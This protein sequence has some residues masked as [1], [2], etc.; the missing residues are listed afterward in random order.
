[1]IRLTRR[2]GFSASHRLHTPA[3]T[4]QQNA[5]LYGKCNSPR[6][7][8][9][10]YVL[11]VS[12]RGPLDES[13]ARVVNV[14]ALDGLVETRVLSRVRHRDLNTEAAGLAGAVPTTES[15]AL[16]I[17]DALREGWREVFPG[18]VP[19]LDR[20]RVHETRKNIFEVPAST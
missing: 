10:N 13:S 17:R 19:A 9:H 12:V 20:V 5:E 2:Y 11:E 6:G 4:D 8:G 18:G 15:L 3:L 1:V 7:H 16:G 14:A